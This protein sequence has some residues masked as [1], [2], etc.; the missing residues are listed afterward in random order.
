M[1]WVI[2]FLQALVARK[3]LSR[4]ACWY[5][6]RKYEIFALEM[7]Y[8]FSKSN[9]PFEFKRILVNFAVCLQNRK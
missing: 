3:K 5:L 8:W 6:E 7:R 4:Q 2:C 9:A 1:F